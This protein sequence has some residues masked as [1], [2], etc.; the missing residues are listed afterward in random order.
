MDRRVKGRASVPACES[1]EGRALLTAVHLSSSA[2]QVAHATAQLKHDFARFVADVRID[3]AGS[4]VTLAEVLA[5][6]QDIIAS[7]Q[8]TAP[9]SGTETTSQAMFDL[10][11][12]TTDAITMGDPNS[13]VG[14][15]RSRPSPSISPRSATP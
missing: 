1:M 7:E 3:Q 10:I 11:Q 15:P 9:P 8:G 6:H 14:T 2:V 13:A 12:R 4:H 5:V